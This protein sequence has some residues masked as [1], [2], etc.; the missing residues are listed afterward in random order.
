MENF[1]NDN[2]IN[3]L[4]GVVI[5]NGNSDVAKSI[6]TNTLLNSMRTNQPVID[7]ITSLVFISNFKN[8]FI[9]NMSI[10]A[11]LVFGIVIHRVT[12]SID[13][14]NYLYEYFMSY[15]NIINLINLIPSKQ[16]REK[17]QKFNGNVV[18]L[19]ID[20][21]EELIYIK[22]QYSLLSMLHKVIK[23][24]PDVNREF[25][26]NTADILGYNSRP[27]NANLY[28]RMSSNN[29][30]LTYDAFEREEQTSSTNIKTILN[31]IIKSPPK[32]GIWYKLESDVLFSF[33]LVKYNP[34][35]QTQQQQQQ[36]QQTQQVSY[37]SHYIM[38]IKSFTMN[39]E[40]ILAYIDS[41]RKE[42]IG[43]L[44][45]Y[46]AE[47][48]R[49]E[50]ERLDNLSNKEFRGDIY[51][52]EEEK[53]NQ[54]TQP[55]SSSNSTTMTSTSTV[56]STR[57]V[58][59]LINT[60]CRPL[61]SIFFKEKD[62][63]YNMLTNFKQKKGIYEK[64][65]HR[66]KIGIMIYGLPGAGKTSL[67]VAIATELKRSIIRVSLK[68]VDL[69]DKK[70]SYILNN[71]KKGYVIILD[72]LDTH[73]A[74]RPRTIEDEDEDTNNLDDLFPL[75]EEGSVCEEGPSVRYNKIEHKFDK[76]GKVFNKFRPPFKNYYKPPP[77]LTLGSFLEAM[78]GISSTE[79]RVV[80]AMTNHPKILDPA[81]IRPGR[82]DIVINMDSLDPNF[83]ILYMKYLFKNFDITEDEIL[84]ACKYANANKISTSILEQACIEKYS[85]GN[86]KTLKECISSVYESFAVLKN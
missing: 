61:E 72:E 79:E 65:P 34:P 86:L 24:Y 58:K 22:Y 7:A 47:V 4:N 36:Q 33:N 49:K 57:Y 82:F 23:K 29:Q 14:L 69:D 16:L 9:K 81:I 15:Y 2:R 85:I 11:V 39:N 63:L 70:L 48:H 68:D 3:D 64:L 31:N 17:L 21:K 25:I 77:K 71:Y 84:D 43:E 55:S 28:T 44:S 56:V 73:K 35:P 54:I 45:A 67:S 40:S 37:P 42:L 53:I 8:P 83:M 1:Q 62:Q 76:I 75:K 19:R 20:N 10:V 32:V 51:E 59:N 38:K 66:H 41:C 13:L 52:I 5:S 80:I 50:N 18:S 30:Y 46:E 12:K 26:D 78:D 27:S 74:F 60:F 6:I